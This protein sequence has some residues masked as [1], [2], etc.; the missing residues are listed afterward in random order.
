M[1]AAAEAHAREATA[2]REQ[3]V[4]ASQQRDSA[5]RDVSPPY[6]FPSLLHPGC[7]II[8]QHPLVQVEEMRAQLALEAE[9]RAARQQA[10]LR[11]QREAQ[12]GR[13]GCEE[14]RRM[15]M[16]ARRALGDAAREQEA[17]RRSN[18]QLRAALRHSEGQR[19]RCGSG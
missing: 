15:G 9:A 18:E 12:E 11:A 3:A 2:L 4:A 19:I 6:P 5:L 13:E 10:L 14:Q 7:S 1:E 16:E 17:L 8:P